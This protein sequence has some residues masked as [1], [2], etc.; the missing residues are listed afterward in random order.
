MSEARIA[1]VKIATNSSYT[2][3]EYRKRKVALITGKFSW[4]TFAS[5]S[6]VLC[7]WKDIISMIVMTLVY[8][9]SALGVTGQDG[10]Y[11]TEFLL[12]KGYEVHGI[13]RRS[14]SFNTGRIE[15]IYKD[16]HDQGEE[17]DWI[18]QDGK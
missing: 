12:D 16:R 14:S 15:H 7:T 11:L 17:D 9:W 8:S 10:S 4:S 2:L 5:R 3:E 18:K 1:D 13:I 6:R